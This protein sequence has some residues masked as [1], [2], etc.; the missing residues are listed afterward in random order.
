MQPVIYL[1]TGLMA[2][3]KSTIGQL[4]AERLEKSVHLRG[5]VFRRMIVTGR[6]DMRENPPREALEQLYL[7]YQLTAEAAK[8]YFDHGFSVVIQ[9]NYYGPALTHMIEFMEGYPLR[10]VVLCPDVATIE[11]RE[12]ERSKTGYTGY[13]A[14]PL[15]A[16]FM[17]ETPRIGFWLDNSKESAKDTVNRILQYTSWD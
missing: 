5:D 11:L 10:V 8:T 7:R 13:D 17:E 14:A 4:L 16:S 3:G 2:S 15:H 9:D 6:E 1:I 12:R